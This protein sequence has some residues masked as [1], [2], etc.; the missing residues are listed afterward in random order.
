MKLVLVT[1]PTTFPV[2]LPT[3]KA[4][5]RVDTD[6]D[7]NYIADLIATA[8]DLVQDITR[9]ALL[10]QTW[11]RCLDGWPWCNGIM[12]PFGNLQSVT[13]VKWKDTL[14]VETTLTLTTDYLVET[15][16]EQ[17]GGIVLPYGCHW[18]IGTLY[19]SNPITI[20]FVCG[21]T[22]AANVPAKIKAGI[23]MT[24]AKLY[25]SRGEDTLGVTVHE[26]KTIYNLLA[27]ARLWDELP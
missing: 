27:S 1:P 2:D 23:L 16:G 20:Q 9:R 10:T 24:V 12:L 13:S 26:D 15:N 8:T 6:E 22:S 11:D 18:P 5:L 25:E 7:D 4:H 3:A 19:P 17:T 14:G 21:W